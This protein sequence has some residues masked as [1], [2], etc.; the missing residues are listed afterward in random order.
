MKRT[1]V[2]LLLVIVALLATVIYYAYRIHNLKNILGLSEQPG[3]FLSEK[4]EDRLMALRDYGIAHDKLDSDLEALG[5][6]AFLPS[7]E[8]HV[9][10]VKKMI[11]NFRRDRIA[12][13]TTE[14]ILFDWPK[15]IKAMKQTYGVTAS[16][17]ENISYW[18]DKGF[19]IYPA[20]Y[21]SYGDLS[22][23][24]KNQTTAIFQLAKKDTSTSDP[25]DWEAILNAGTNKVFDFGDL[26]PPK[27]T[28]R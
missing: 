20:K 10:T 17:W 1:T 13:D 5:A 24:H 2:F 3:N 8:I 4:L 11:A 15:I 19:V 12:G 9:D 25:N 23:N 7:D 14:T 16:D 28:I 21:A 6:M 27:N 22:S 18:D 26:T